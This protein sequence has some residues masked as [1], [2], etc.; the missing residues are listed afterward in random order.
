[1]N[2]TRI[3]LMKTTKLRYLY[4]ALIFTFLFASK[5]Y[6]LSDAELYQQARQAGAKGQNDMAFMYLKMI[7]DTTP[8]S[9]FHKHSLFAI[10]EYY[11][12][13]N[14]RYD[15]KRKFKKFIQRYPKSKDA[16]FAHAYL[17][18][19]ARLNHDEESVKT[20]EKEIIGL[21]QLSFLFRKSKE[22]EYK[23]TLS[24]KH[25]AVYFIDRIEIYTG[26]ELFEKISF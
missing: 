8:N 26:G 12:L 19:I 11:F 10:G 22:Y 1:M 13:V 3:D 16:I 25:K 24:T 2:T 15:S 17:L 7:L 21:E 4:I 20:I 6:P 14:D 5:A 9:K 18:K 23:S